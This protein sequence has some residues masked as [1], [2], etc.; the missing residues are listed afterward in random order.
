MTFDKRILVGAIAA[1][2]L[3]AVGG[4]L[5]AYVLRDTHAEDVQDDADDQLAIAGA[6]IAVQN[7]FPEATLV[8]FGKVF[9][10]Q[11]GEVVSVCG[12]VDVQQPQDSFDGPERFVWSDGALVV[13]E[14]DGT[15]AVNAKWA[16]VCE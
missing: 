4:G 16:D 14:A 11:D 10:H 12:D 9:T 7:R 13:E 5:V 6:K 1:V 3:L 15:D 8:N 2:V